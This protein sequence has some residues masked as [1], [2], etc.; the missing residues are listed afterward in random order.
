LILVKVYDEIKVVDGSTLGDCEFDV[1]VFLVELLEPGVEVFHTVGPQ[2]NAVVSILFVVEWSPG[3]L[4]YESFHQLAYEDVG[5]HA[6]AWSAH[7]DA[8]LLQVELFVECKVVV[9]EH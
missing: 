6:C 3:L 5:D 2:A 9:A 1:F 8:V 7:C 4:G